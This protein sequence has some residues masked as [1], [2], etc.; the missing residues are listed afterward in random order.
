[1][2]YISFGCMNRQPPTHGPPTTLVATGSNNHQLELS[3]A[4]LQLQT[5]NNCAL[6]FNGTN[7]EHVYCMDDQSQLARTLVV[8]YVE[9][10]HTWR[11]LGEAKVRQNVRLIQNFRVF[12]FKI[13]KLTEREALESVILTGCH[14]WKA[15]YISHEIKSVITECCIV[16]DGR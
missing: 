5:L 15:P 3:Y 8:V 16:V 11:P 10:F 4:S 13:F 14:S 6:I 12:N 2:S 1:M 9:V 7:F